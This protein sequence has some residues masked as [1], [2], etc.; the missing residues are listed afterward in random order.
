MTTQQKTATATWTVDRAHSNVEFRVKHLMI[1][2]VRGNF[3]DFEA[4]LRIDQEHPENSSVTASIDVA[5]IDTN[6]EGRDAHLRSD[7][8][9]NAER[10]P[11]ITFQSRKVESPD[12]SRFTMTGDLTIRD[13]TRPVTLEGALEG[14]IVDPRGNERAAFSATAEI[15]R[16]EFGVRWNQVLETGGVTVSDKVQIILYIEAIKNAS[17]SAGM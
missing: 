5:S 6:E 7:D 13:V 16:K 3:R 4:S 12:G 2:T 8:F 1:S 14:R 15:S 10:F 9:F 17:A 11:K